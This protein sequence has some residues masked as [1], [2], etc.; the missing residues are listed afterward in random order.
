MSIVW[1]QPR[2]GKLA[3]VFFFSP[4]CKESSLPCYPTLHDF[5]L[6]TKHVY[7]LAQS[8]VQAGEGFH[9]YLDPVYQVAASVFLSLW[10]G[11]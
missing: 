11:F 5:L 8:R 9:H 7:W 10:G 2:M 6:P 4:I 1:A 3:A